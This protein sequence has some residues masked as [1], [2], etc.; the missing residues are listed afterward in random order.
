MLAGA[1]DDGICLLEFVDRR[2]LETEIERLSELLSARFVPG[3]SKH[4]D[5][6]DLQMEEYFSGKR[7]DFDIPLVLPGTPFQKKVWREL[8]AI[9]YG[10]T[11][12]YKEQA[13]VLGLPNAVR[14]VAKANGDNRIAILVPC[15]RVI[16]A[17]GELLGYGGGLWRKQF[18]LNLE[19]GSSYQMSS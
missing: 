15:H 6:L 2:M 17:D 19:S 13:E 11:R 18:L 12:S 10:S 7:R 1:T 3:F 4:F 8:Q 5:A 16:G 14:A 9:P